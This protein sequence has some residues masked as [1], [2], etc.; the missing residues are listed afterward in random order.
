MGHA[1][2]Q[3]IIHRDLKPGNIIL[4]QTNQA[5][6]TDLGLAM[7]RLAG[8]AATSKRILKLVGTAEYAAPEQLRNPDRVSAASDVWSIGA[9]LYFLSQVLN[10]LTVKP[11]SI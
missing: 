7:D 10:H 2:N 6:V 3:G 9:T 11:C 4:S 5:V 1:H 8:Q